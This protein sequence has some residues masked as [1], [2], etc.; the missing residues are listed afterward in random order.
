M[1]LMQFNHRPNNVNK[2]E[3]QLSLTNRPT[4]VHADLIDTKRHEAQLFMLSVKSCPLVDDCDLLVGLSD[5]FL[6]FS[7]LTPSDLMWKN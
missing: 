6:P 3:A 5:F 2:Q 1:H 4:L 7:H